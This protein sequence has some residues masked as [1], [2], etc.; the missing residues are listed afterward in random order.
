MGP[1]ISLKTTSPSRPT[2]M[3]H[4]AGSFHRLRAPSSAPLVRVSASEDAKRRIAAISE[5]YAED[6]VALR[7]GGSAT[8][9]ACQ[10]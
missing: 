4:L 6:A 3:S 2:Q 1:F 7:A 5:L 9:H 8:G 10:Q